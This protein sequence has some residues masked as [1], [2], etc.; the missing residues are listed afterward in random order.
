ME[1]KVEATRE[2]Y[3]CLL[4]FVLLVVL[5]VVELKA[6]TSTVWDKTN[7]WE[8]FEALFSSSGIFS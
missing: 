3:V 6:A 8:D 7:R 4:N 2:L 1:A 5:M